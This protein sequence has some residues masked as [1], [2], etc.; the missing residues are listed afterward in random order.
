MNEKDTH[1][2]MSVGNYTTPVTKVV[3]CTYCL[4][5]ASVQ[6]VSVLDAHTF[7]TGDI[8]VQSGRYL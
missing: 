2:F 6:D 4:I 1:Y 7:Q 5:H 8:H 3:E